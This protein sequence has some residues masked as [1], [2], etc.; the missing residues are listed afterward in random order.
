M[1]HEATDRSEST[2]RSGD[3][4]NINVGDVLNLVQA[5][6]IKGHV[7]FS[8]GSGNPWPTFAWLTA[9]LA[10]SALA[11]LFAWLDLDRMS[12]ATSQASLGL[13][14]FLTVAGL[15]CLGG[16]G[17]GL[18]RCTATWRAYRSL[19]MRHRLLVAADHLAH[20]TMATWEREEE[21]LRLYDPKALPVRWRTA[22]SHQDQW[23]TIRNRTV[24]EPLDLDGQFADILTVFQTI[25]SGRMVVL[26]GPGSGKS[27]LAVHFLL[28]HLTHRRD[29]DPTGP[30]AVLLSLS[31]WNPSRTT[32][33]DWVVN[34]I[35]RDYPQ[36]ADM[37]GTGSSAATELFVS[38]RLLLV[39]DGF[40]EL[41]PETRPKV[42]EALNAMRGRSTGKV[43]LT[44]RPEEYE[45]AVEEAGVLRAAAVVELEP[46][47]TEELRHF[48]PLTVDTGGGSAG[49]S[50]DKND[51]GDRGD[52]K[53]QPVLD[54]LACSGAVDDA[55]CEASSS[56]SAKLRDVLST[57][58]MI[59][60]A[61]TAYSDTSAS[62]GELLKTRRFKEK[63]DI[64]D[65]LLDQF[66]TAVYRTS[67][68]TYTNPTDRWTVDEARDWL[69][70]L[71]RRLQRL[72][73]R[74]II[75]WRLSPGVPEACRLLLETVALG[76]TL[77]VTGWLVYGQPVRPEVPPPPYALGV[78][79]VA[80]LIALLARPL[81]GMDNGIAPRRLVV[82]GRLRTFC[83]QAAI[84]AAVLLPIG[85]PMRVDPV[86]LVV[87]PLLFAL[88]TFVD[89]AVDISQAGNPQELLRADR[90][91]VMTLAPVYALRN[92]GPHAIR[93]WLLSWAALGPL[94]IAAAWHRS[95]GRDAVGPQVWTVAGVGALIAL[96]LL[97]V[98]GSAWW[99]YTATR[100][101][102]A[103]SGRLPW[104]LASFLEDAHR[105]GVL[106]QAGGVYE[107]RHARL[108]DRLAGGTS[109]EF[110]PRRA[111]LPPPG[112]NLTAMP[113]ALVAL[114]TVSFTPGATGPY[115][116]ANVYCPGLD[117]P[118]G[119]QTDL[120]EDEND[121]GTGS[122]PAEADETAA[123]E[124]TYTLTCQWIGETDI[125][126]APTLDSSSWYPIP[127]TSYTGTYGL[128]FVITTMPPETSR[129][130]VDMASALFD[131]LS[132]YNVSESVPGLGDEAL[133]SP[134]RNGLSQLNVRAGNIVI[135]TVVTDNRS[136]CYNTV[137]DIAVTQ[138]AETLKEIGATS[139]TSPSGYK[140]DPWCDSTGGTADEDAAETSDP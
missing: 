63:E 59:A 41:P 127:D 134:W 3:T 125:D 16:T 94:V 1:A 137:R 46:L 128:A 37:G 115:D 57:P 135:Q 74:E 10:M 93:S 61:R 95:G 49:G 18:R 82:R 83:T 72:G 43:L 136:A 26:G 2:E 101:A 112:A 114:L 76:L 34:R 69:S 120:G 110:T 6:D 106:R 126:S 48:L 67:P 22:P 55:D 25:P 24:D 108:Q 50:N 15:V 30:V 35:A 54:A 123:S 97:G 139:G 113:L 68:S 9:S 33:R 5:R 29:H 107:F 91:A 65:H 117:V 81:G 56:H 53:W 42:I 100:I 23:A 122:Y 89:H 75:W 39:L 102:L 84:A 96:A 98:A 92:Q 130:A 131:Q 129:S 20:A 14:W 99:G 87:L 47:G 7:V 38:G 40:D 73:Q 77:A 66:V 58:L 32:F 103:V 21:S 138:T 51:R 105:R 71:A 13:T 64:E 118:S 19:G 86:V 62:P 124:P 90:T 85:L 12:S 119:Y 104:S 52:S 8:G 11:G 80:C 31:S 133:I 78:Q 45:L 79:V 27:V 121:F 111:L 140:R 28:E 36:L 88:R 109:V 4:T 44:S 70:T 116:F 132:E 17:W 60:L